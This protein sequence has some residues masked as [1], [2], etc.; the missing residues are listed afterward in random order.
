[1][2]SHAPTPRP[3]APGWLVWAALLVI[4]VVWGSTYLAIRVVVDT[5]PPLLAAGGR[6][7]TAGAIMALPLILRGPRRMRVTR[8]ELA[9]S[10]FVAAMLLLFGNGLVS[11]GERDVPSGLAAL[12]IGIVPLIVLIMRG[13]GGERITRVGL[14]GVALGF[15]GL[16][17]LVVPRGVD[18]TVAVGGIVMLIVASFTWA[19]GSFY[20]RR[21]RLP[22]D[23]LVSTALQLVLGGVFL[24]AA[25][26]L[27]GEAGQLRVEEFS[28]AS[29]LA[30]VYLVTFGS[31]IAYTAYTWLLQNAPI[32]RIATY[33]Y[34]NPVVAVVLGWLILQEEIG[35]SMLVGAAMIVASVAFIVWTESQPS[36]ELPDER[37]MVPRPSARHGASPLAGTGGPTGVQGRGRPR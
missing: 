30:F 5:M 6:F 8:A 3:A 32:S 18:G 2:A 7:A 27:L 35:A 26:L 23:P 12:I 34:V 33:A 22:R 24:L 11:L 15:A 21:L 1:M 10:A 17:V 25:G 37:D 28:T 14:V 16:A 31:I 4:Y 20:S 29:V 36:A 13:V 19:L 9:G